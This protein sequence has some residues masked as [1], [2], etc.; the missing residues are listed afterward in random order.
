MGS[1]ARSTLCVVAGIALLSIE[2]NAQSTTGNFRQG[3]PGEYH[4]FRPQ[5][6]EPT[7]QPTQ[8]RQAAPQRSAPRAPYNNSHGARPGRY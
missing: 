8:Q 1:I 5:R 2:A 7:Q 6:F 4:V 3:A